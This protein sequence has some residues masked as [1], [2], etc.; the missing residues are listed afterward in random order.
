MEKQEFLDKLRMALSGRL[1]SETV[2]DTV[3]YYEDYINTET[4]MGREEREVMDSLG[5]PRLIARTIIETKGGQGGSVYAEES[6]RAEDKPQQ[7]R[8]VPGWV[9]LVLVVILVV[10]VISAVF[11]FLSAFWPLIAVMAVVLFLVKLFRDWMN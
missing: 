8:T 2:A 1:A 9:W 10:L 4:R 11:R 7:Y 3:R 6:E 5:D